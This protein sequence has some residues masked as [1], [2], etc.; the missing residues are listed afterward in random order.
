MCVM[1]FFAK[2]GFGAAA[3]LFASG[4][5]TVDRAR[6]AQAEAE[7]AG[8]DEPVAR[9]SVQNVNFKGYRLADYVAWAMNHRPGIEAAYLSISNA[10]LE[11]VRVTS[12]R[13]LQ[14][15]LS[16]GFSQSTANRN[17]HFSGHQDRGKFTSDVSFDLLIYD[18]G[19]TTRSLKSPART[20]S[21]T[22]SISVRRSRFSRKGRSRNLT[23]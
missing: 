8:K 3:L 11:L 2:I 9:E 16:S 20:S 12:D 18:F 7:P 5:E 22:L 23:C 6:R 1:S 10:V 19:R 14:A 4:C 21:S 13:A 15:N 17:S